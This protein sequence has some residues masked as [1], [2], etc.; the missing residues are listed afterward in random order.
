MIRELIAQYD[1]RIKL[2]KELAES[3]EDSYVRELIVKE[4]E[5]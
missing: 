5:M 3:Q 2:L 1:E 4:L